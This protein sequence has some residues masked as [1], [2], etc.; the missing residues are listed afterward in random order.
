ML[1]EESLVQVDLAHQQLQ[2]LRRQDGIKQRQHAEAIVALEN[3]ATTLEML[4]SSAVTE[5][6]MAR[7]TE[8]S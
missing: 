1:H 5:Q 2:E 6:Q 3:R 8:L 7:A 4:R